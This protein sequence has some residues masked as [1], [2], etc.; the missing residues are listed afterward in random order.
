MPARDEWSGSSGR[1][2]KLLGMAIRM[3]SRRILDGNYKNIIKIIFILDVVTG[4][5][6]NNTWKGGFNNGKQIN[7][8]S[9]RR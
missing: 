8:G 7:A 5:A 2:A 1:P 9:D 3:Q 6:Y 4:K